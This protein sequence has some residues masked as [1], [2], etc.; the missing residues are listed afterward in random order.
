MANLQIGEPL[1]EDQ[2]LHRAASRLVTEFPDLIDYNSEFV[3]WVQEPREVRT[4]D[5][6]VRKLPRVAVLAVISDNP[7]HK[8]TRQLTKGGMLLEHWEAENRGYSGFDSQKDPVLKLY[9]PIVKS[10]LGNLN[11]QKALMN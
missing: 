4:H 7:R 1:L 9:R 8:N 3:S 5:G 6:L 10:H 2:R 11:N